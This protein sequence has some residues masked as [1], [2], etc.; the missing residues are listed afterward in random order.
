MRRGRRGR[1][2]ASCLD[3]AK[4]GIP[5]TVIRWDRHIR[6]GQS[7]GHD[8]VNSG[9]GL[10]LERPDRAAAGQFL[11]QRLGHPRRPRGRHAV[12]PLPP[13]ADLRGRGKRRHRRHRQRGAGAEPGEEGDRRILRA[14]GDRAGPVRLCLSVG[15]DVPPH[16]RLGPQ[17]RRHGGDLGHRYRDLGPD[18]QACRKAGLQ[19]S[20]RPH[21]GQHPLLLLETLCR[22]DQG[23]A[24]R[25]RGGDEAGLC[26]VQDA[27][28]LR[29]AR[30]HGRHAREPEAGRG[31]ARG[32]RLGA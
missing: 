4:T 24:G 32:H 17:G 30:R 11:H 19:A 18:G 6:G 3:N 8:Q 21:Q 22:A 31:G 10:E 13:V 5:N 9:A 1:P 12:L 2:R 25:G 28:R 20:R 23:H 16:A 7:H 29:S 26:R 14:D 15:E 27:L